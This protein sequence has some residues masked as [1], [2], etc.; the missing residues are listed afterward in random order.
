MHGEFNSAKIIFNYIFLNQTFPRFVSFQVRIQDLCTGGGAADFFLTSRSGVAMVTKM[1]AS[2][3]G[4]R[5][6]RVPSLPPRSAPVFCLP[7]IPLSSILVLW[8]EIVLT[9]RKSECVASC[10]SIFFNNVFGRHTQSLF[11]GSLMPNSVFPVIHL[12][13]Y[14][15]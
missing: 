2:K 3:W 4:I 7:P 5:R 6:G 10:H 15:C 8:K 13:C 1:C 11:L 14:T 12:W 9:R